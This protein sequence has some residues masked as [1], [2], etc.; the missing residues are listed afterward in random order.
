MGIGPLFPSM[1]PALPTQVLGW[2]RHPDLSSSILKKNSRDTN[3]GQKT[4]EIE[5]AF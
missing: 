3:P 2:E 1:S 4:N 5:V